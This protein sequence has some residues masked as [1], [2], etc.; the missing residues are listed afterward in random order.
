MPNWGPEQYFQSVAGIGDPEVRCYINR[1]VSISRYDGFNNEKYNAKEDP[2][3]K[4]CIINCNGPDGEYIDLFD[5]QRWFD[6]NRE[7]INNLKTE[8]EAH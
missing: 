3:F 7:M 6:N 8:C 1:G 4:T 2:W 5:L